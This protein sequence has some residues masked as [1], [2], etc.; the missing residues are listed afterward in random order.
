[1]TVIGFVELTHAGT[2]VSNLTADPITAY[3]AVAACY[4][5]ICFGVSRLGRWYEARSAAGDRTAAD[6]GAHAVPLEGVT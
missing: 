3:T 4:F 5:V 2:I 6:D 1:M